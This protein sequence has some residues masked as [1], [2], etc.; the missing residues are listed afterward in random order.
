MDAR[1]TSIIIAVEA[2]TLVAFVASK[3]GRGKDI[4]LNCLLCCLMTSYGFLDY[5]TLH[6]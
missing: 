1:V 4:M 6:T 3:I 5:L 2:V